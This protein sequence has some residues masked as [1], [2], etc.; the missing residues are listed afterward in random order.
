MTKIICLIHKF[1]LFDFQKNVIVG[2]VGLHRT[3]RPTLDA[4]HQQRVSYEVDS[5]CRARGA[6]NVDELK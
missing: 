4:A 3:K 6:Q 2:G 1:Y 5:R